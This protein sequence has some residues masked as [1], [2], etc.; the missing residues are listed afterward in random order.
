MCFVSLFLILIETY[1][2]RMTARQKRNILSACIAVLILLAAHFNLIDLQ[3]NSVPEVVTPT[4]V[5]AAS[6]G[7]G[8]AL[9]VRTVD[10]DTLEVSEDG[11]ADSEKIRLLGVNTPE[12]VDPRK[13]VECFGKEASHF[14]DELMT[15]KRV[16]L[17]SDPTADNVDKYGRLLRFVELE[18]GTNLNE[19]LLREGYAYA[20]L[21]FPLS[22]EKKALYHA[23]EQEAKAAER[24]LWS[25]DTCAGLH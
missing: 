17:V 20:Y 10:G 4:P 13:P 7:F 21:S 23:L 15:G 24:G 18:D 2:I 19:T 16:E 11:K 25:P 5:S 6:S 12:S 9:V 1:D 3:S 22:A 8:N 14:T